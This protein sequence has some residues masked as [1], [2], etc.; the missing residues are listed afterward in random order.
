MKYWPTLVALAVAALWVCALADRCRVGSGARAAEPRPK[1]ARGTPAASKSGAA[2]GAEHPTEEPS[3]DEDDSGG[4]IDPLGPN[5]ACYVCHLTFVQEEISKIHLAEDTGCIECH[6]VSAPHANDENIGATPPDIVYSRNQIDPACAECHDTHDVPA[7]Q[8]VGR[9][10][11]RGLPASET[12]VCTD[13]HGRHRID[14]AA[15]AK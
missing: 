11:Q 3:P 5:A 12:P 14:R 10:L 7:E 4:F 13:C 2:D 6:G 1:E 8:V 15:E 9:F